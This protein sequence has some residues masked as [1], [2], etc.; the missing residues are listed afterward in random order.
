[1]AGESSLQGGEHHYSGF[2]AIEILTHVTHSS[3]T[4]IVIV[5]VLFCFVLFFF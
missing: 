2:S 4:V 3:Q 5:V 1:M